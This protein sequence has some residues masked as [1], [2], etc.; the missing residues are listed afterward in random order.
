MGHSKIFALYIIFSQISITTGNVPL[1]NNI[2]YVQFPILFKRND[3]YSLLINSFPSLSKK[4]FNFVL[5]V[6]PI[7]GP[8]FGTASLCY[9]NCFCFC[10]S[11]FFFLNRKFSLISSIKRF[12]MYMK[13]C[14]VHSG[15]VRGQKEGSTG[16]LK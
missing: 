13:Y 11:F 5:N 9:K 7:S 6:L 8:N 16:R 3:L 14:Q 2:P 1:F 12:T 15:P 4:Y 10:I